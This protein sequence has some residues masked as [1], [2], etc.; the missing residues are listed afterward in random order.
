M[1]PL[2]KQ[3]PGI[4]MELKAG[5]DCSDAQLAEL[6]QTALKQINDRAYSVDLT[7]QG[8]QTVLKYGIAFSG[9]KVS[10]TAELQENK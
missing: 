8:I 3:L 2:N 6:A 1:L 5:K 4:L 7:A 9:K 10:I